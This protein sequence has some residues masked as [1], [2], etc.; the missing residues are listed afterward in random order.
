MFGDF[1]TNRAEISETENPKLAQAYLNFI[2][3]DNNFEYIESTSGS[4]Q[5]ERPG[6]LGDLS[7]RN[8]VAPRNGFLYV[9]VENE[10]DKRVSF[11][12]LQIYHYTG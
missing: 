8:I 10:S 3:L 11:D 12:N 2:F 1:I 6:E 4:L 5:A 7:V 9:F